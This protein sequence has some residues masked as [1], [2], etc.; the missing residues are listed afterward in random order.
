[1]LHI[2]LMTACQKRV[3]M[4]QFCHESRMKKEKSTSP[5]QF[6]GSLEACLS[7]RKRVD[8][9]SFLYASCLA[10]YYSSSFPVISF[11]QFLSHHVTLLEEY[12]KH[13]VHPV[14]Y[15]K[16]AIVD[17]YIS[18]SN[19]IMDISSSKPLGLLGPH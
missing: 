12:C 1:M 17:T 8:D 2:F 16:D 5:L 14:K 10:N 7:Y 4:K 3:K 6:S 19:W 15:Y 9:W 13:G 11:Q 18:I